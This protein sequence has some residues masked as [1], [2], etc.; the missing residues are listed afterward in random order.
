M[1]KFRVVAGQ[2]VEAPG[3][4]IAVR[5]PNGELPQSVGSARI[6]D[7]LRLHPRLFVGIADDDAGVE[8]DRHLASGRRGSRSG[9]LD[10]RFQ[11]LVLV[12]EDQVAIEELSRVDVTCVGV[13]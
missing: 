7:P 8:P 12:P 11:P 6:E 3:Y 10:F 1:L 4:A 9:A 13:T 5:V 2:F